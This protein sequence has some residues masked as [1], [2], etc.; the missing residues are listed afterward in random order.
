VSEPADDENEGFSMRRSVLHIVFILTTAFLL[1]G[2]MS[3]G[4]KAL[5]DSREREAAQL[6][7]AGGEGTAQTADEDASQADEKEGEKMAEAQKGSNKADEAAAND[8]NAKELFTT[9]CGVCHMLSDAGSSG[10]TGPDLD[11]LMPD[12]ETVLS[13]IDSGSEDGVMAPDLLTGDDAKAV[14]AYVAAVAGK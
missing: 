5:D 2:C 6:E 8:A 13:Q 1:I 11:E 14:A 7:E 12:L 4:P 3:P 10:T 9:T